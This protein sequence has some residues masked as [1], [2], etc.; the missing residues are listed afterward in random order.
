[1]LYVPSLHCAVAPGGGPLGLGNGRHT[2]CPLTF[3]YVPFGQGW[4]GCGAGV[5]VVCGGAVVVVVVVVVAALVNSI[6]S[7][8]A[9]VQSL[10]IASCAITSGTWPVHTN[11]LSR[12]STASLSTEP[13]S[14]FFRSGQRF[15]MS[16]LPPSSSGI[17]WSMTYFERLLLEMWYSARTFVFVLLDTLRT[18][19]V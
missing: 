17:R 4:P 18:A 12:N 11:W 10:V 19:F 15:L 2:T 8:T 9:V 6:E 5:A 14:P 1:M 7:S 13:C 3:T 16:L